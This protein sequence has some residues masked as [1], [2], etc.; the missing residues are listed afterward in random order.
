MGICEPYTKRRF[1]CQAL[2]LDRRPGSQS[3]LSF[4]QKVFN[5]VKL[6]TLCRPVGFFHTNSLIHVFR[7][8]GVVF[9]R[10]SLAP[11][12]LGLRVPFIGT[13]DPSPTPETQPRSIIPR[14]HTF[15][16]MQTCKYCSPFKPRLLHWLLQQTGSLLDGYKLFLCSVFNYDQ[17]TG[18]I[19]VIAG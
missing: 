4:I 16:I 9:Q 5:W 2:M 13:K 8:F 7:Y 15:G 17:W 10:L 19:N 6:R 12:F 18:K 1:V 3:S 14:S 11:Q